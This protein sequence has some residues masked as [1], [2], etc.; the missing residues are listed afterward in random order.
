MSNTFNTRLQNRGELWRR[1]W[2]RYGQ[3]RQNGQWW[4]GNLFGI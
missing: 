1:G 4:Q 3:R 2:P